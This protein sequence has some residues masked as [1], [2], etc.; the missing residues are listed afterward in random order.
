LATDATGTPTSPDGIPKYNTGVDSPSGKG[1]NAIVDAIQTALNGRV[2]L[3]GPA[4]FDVPIY[5]SGTSSWKRSGTDAKKIQ[6]SHLQPSG[7][8]GFVLT[9]VGGASAWA[10]NTGT[11]GT[12]LAY[13]QIIADSAG[14]T[15]TT[16]GTSVAVI[17]P[18]ASVAY[19][20]TKVRIEVWAPQTGV[21]TT[22]AIFGVLYRD[23][24]VVGQWE[25][26]NNGFGTGS[27]GNHSIFYDTPSA[28]S[29]T[30]TVKVYVSSGTG[31]IK[32]GAGGAGNLLP[33]FIRVTKA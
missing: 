23:S 14:V 33:A 26:S 6:V 21:S 31:T 10:A 12:E 24:T 15:A 3:T 19:D 9:T 25:W 7:T 5:D 17:G 20:G 30:Y 22:M 11:I 1:L 18:T 28:A 2:G 27:F 13:T 4:N 8:N 16:E 29:H 32:A